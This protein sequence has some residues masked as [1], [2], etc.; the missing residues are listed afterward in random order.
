MSWWQVALAIVVILAVAAWQL[1]DS[2]ETVR[3][4]FRTRRKLAAAV[5]MDQARVR[6]AYERALANYRSNGTLSLEDEIEFA[7]FLPLAES[8]FSQ[9]FC[10]SYRALKASFAEGRRPGAGADVQR[11]IAELKRELD[12][13]FRR[14][15]G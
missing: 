8:C 15:M 1:W 9:E 4:I 12:E 7:S 5:T 13:G 14:E 3:R 2:L 6:K 11:R 10:D